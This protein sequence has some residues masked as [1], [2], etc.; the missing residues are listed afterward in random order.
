MQRLSQQTEQKRPFGSNSQ[1]GGKAKYHGFLRG[2][3]GTEEAK[4]IHCTQTCLQ[5]SWSCLATGLRQA[6][7]REWGW[8]SAT[9]LHFNPNFKQ[10]LTLANGSGFAIKSNLINELAGPPK[11]VNDCL[12]TV[13]LLL[14]GKL[15]ASLVS[16]YTPTMT[17][18]DDTKE[19]F[20]QDLKSMTAAVAIT[21][22]LIILGDFSAR[23]GGDSESWVRVLGT[24]GIGSCNSNGLMLLETSVAHGLLITN[25]ILHLPLQNKMLW[26]HPHS[27][28]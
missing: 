8:Q 4:V 2:W 6:W 11:G 5:S 26:M 28:Y 12:M 14:S 20:Y 7:V 21:D 17:N 19:G 15:H 18:S 23:V 22:K 1:E 10:V 27:K 3:S 24:E 25:S 13:H 9:L 16:A